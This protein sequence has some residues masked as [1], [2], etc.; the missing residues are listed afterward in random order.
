MCLFVFGACFLVGAV[1]L[2]GGL[3]ETLTVLEE[4]FA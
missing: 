3:E 4:G 2:P 1:L